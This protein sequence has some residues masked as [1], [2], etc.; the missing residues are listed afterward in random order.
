MLRLYWP[1]EKNPSILNGTWKPPAIK[2][3]NVVMIASVVKRAGCLSRIT[4][5]INEANIG[6]KSYCPRPEGGVIGWFRSRFL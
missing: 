1:K 6:L 3:A 2:P 5:R 4:A